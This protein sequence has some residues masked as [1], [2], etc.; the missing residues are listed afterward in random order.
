MARTIVIIHPGGLGDLLLAV[1][2]IYGLRARFPGHQLLLCAQ[3]QASEFLHECR[4]ID[5]WMSVETAACTALFGGS[6]PQDLLLSDWLTR[7][8]LAVAWTRDESGTL[9]AV[10]KHSGAATVLVQSP[11]CSTLN[12]A[13]QSDRFAEILQAP[14][15]EPGTMNPLPVP[16]HLREKASACLRE[17]HFPSDRSLVLIH[18]GS[19]SR[20]K[21]VRPEVLA[22]VVQQLHTQGLVPLIL[23]GP[24]DQEPVSHL[25]SQMPIQPPVLRSLSLGLVAG[26]LSRVELYIGHDSGITHL[27][28]LLGIPTVVVFGP[29]N[30]E[31]W[32][33]RGSQVVIVQGAPCRCLSWNDVT[34]CAEKPCLQVSAEAIVAACKV[35]EFPA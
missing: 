7:C 13:H 34:R 6:H 20:H 18:P 22:S 26:I 4:L 16:A 3:D 5:R 32:A 31:R 8:D 17:Y 12:A 35:K 10:L 2:A 27:S 11:F 21:C 15:V 28:A 25:L 19:G 1:P 33:P 29:T 14:A 9:A 30:P 23:E 24:A